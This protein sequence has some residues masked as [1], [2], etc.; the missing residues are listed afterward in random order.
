MSNFYLNSIKYSFDFYR[1][2]ISIYKVHSPYLYS[3]INDVIPSKEHYSFSPIEFLRKKLLD[4]NRSIS[5][6][7]FGAGSRLENK[8]SRAINEIAKN[9]LSPKKQ[10][11]TMFWIV[12]RLQ[13]KT[14]IELG[15]SLGI[16]TLYL[17]LANKETQIISF[18]GNPNSINIAQQ[19]A[20]QLNLKN[21]KFVEGSFDKTLQPEIDR[22]KQ[23]DIA[24]I[25]GNHQ[26]Q[27]TIDYFHVFLPK[28]HEK[29]ILIFDDIY[30]SPGMKKAWEEIKQH[31][32]VKASLDLYTYG[33]IFFDSQF[34]E[35]K[36]IKLLPVIYKPWQLLN[37]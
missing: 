3:F 36:H 22:L 13:P 17:A 19:Q 26:Y 16:S 24:F 29:S 23:I 2:A 34:L 21:I 25:D 32:S 33:I 30:W 6:V 37:L 4:D 18:E 12:N 20:D 11:Q 5:M 1:S 15:S 35:V 14:V 8:L 31:P 27:A 10:C 28:V 7:D 9:S